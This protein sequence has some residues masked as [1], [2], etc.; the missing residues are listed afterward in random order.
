M[1]PPQMSL[2]KDLALY[3]SDCQHAFYINKARFPFIFHCI[4]KSSPLSGPKNV[5]SGNTKVSEDLGTEWFGKNDSVHCSEMR[6]H[7]HVIGIA[8][9]SRL[10]C[11][12][13]DRGKAINVRNSA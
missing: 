6:N 4:E 12:T 8:S 9:G 3:L 13:G 1:L 5:P 7:R 11:V 10:H 2:A